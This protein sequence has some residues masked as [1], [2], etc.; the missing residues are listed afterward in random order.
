MECDL[1]VP[2][3]GVFCYFGQYLLIMR[4]I[5]KNRRPLS[6]VGVI[7]LL[8]VL[9]ACGGSK[10]AAAFPTERAPEFFRARFTTTQGSFELESR[11]EWSPAA[12]DRLYQLIK[13][14][15]YSDVAFF[16]VIPNFVA[17]FGISN[18]STLYQGWN[19]IKVADEPVVQSNYRG[20]IA[21]ARDQP[22]TRT[23]QLYINLV[24]NLRL[25]TVTFNGV[26]GFPVVARI[27]EGMM[28]AD[29]LYDG[30][31][32]AIQDQQDTIARYG[33]TFLRKNYPGLD[34]VISA[35]ILE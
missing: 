24:D 14:G 21:F 16:R 12:V 27:T 23:T 30:Y 17:Q 33:N 25:D 6:A 13:T 2:G 31:G 19:A 11:R 18:D 8:A 3:K 32:P 9:T 4:N 20:T 5:L 22:G 15:Y 10:S 7:G 1:P 29:A 26:R 35:E 28:V 34:Y